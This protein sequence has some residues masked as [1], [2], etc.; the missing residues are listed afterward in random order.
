M[1]DL[2]RKGYQRPLTED[3]LYD[4]K[5]TLNSQPLTNKFLK[6]WNDELTREKPSIF[7]M[8]FRA[9]GTLLIIMGVLYCVLETGCK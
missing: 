8:L 7:R 4:N 9:Y 5:P 2:F 1:K 3:D 6:L